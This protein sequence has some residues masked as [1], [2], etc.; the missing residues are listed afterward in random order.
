[1]LTFAVLLIAGPALSQS[2]AGHFHSTSHWAYEAV[3]FPPH[4][5]VGWPLHSLR[6]QHYYGSVKPAF[7]TPW[8]G[9][10]WTNHVAAA[11]GG[12]VP[13]TLYPYYSH[14]GYYSAYRPILPFTPAPWF[15]GPTA[16]P[17]SSYQLPANYWSSIVPGKKQSEDDE[18]EEPSPGD[19]EE[20]FAPEPDLLTAPMASVLQVAR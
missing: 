11:Y 14:H 19:E 8:Q 9:G 6:M 2:Q 10:Y 20:E 12:R 16:N 3:T 5:A 1:M 4:I 17:F 15:Y 7:G 18:E 13:A